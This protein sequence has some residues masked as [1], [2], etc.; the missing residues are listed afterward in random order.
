MCE[1]ERERE[2]GKTKRKLLSPRE[3]AIRLLRRNRG[4]DRRRKIAAK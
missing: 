4:K 1:R 2:R 3:K